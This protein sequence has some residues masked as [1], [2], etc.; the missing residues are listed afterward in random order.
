MLTTALLPAIVTLAE[1]KNWRVRGC[2]VAP[3]AGLRRAP[4]TG[5][6]RRRRRAIIKHVP[7]LAQQLGVQFFD[8][9][10][11]RD[12]GGGGGGATRASRTLGMTLACVQGVPNTRANR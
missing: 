12:G 2:D 11:L 7:L 8:E 6:R 4:T 1:D 9:Q 3:I 10:V 5:R